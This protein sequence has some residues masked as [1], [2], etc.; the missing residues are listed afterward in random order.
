MKNKICRKCLN[1]NVKKD[2]FKRWKQRYKCCNCWYVFQNNRR[3]RQNTALW[4]EYGIWK[5]TYKQ[6][7][8]KHR[9][10]IPSIQ[11]KLDDVQ[12]NKQFIIP[13]ETVIIIDTTY[14]WRSFGIM[15][16]RS[17]ELRKNLFRKEVARET[18]KLYIDWIQYLK[19]QWWKILAIVSDGKRWL[20]WWFW[21][22]PTQMCIFHQQQI[23]R[24]YITKNPKLEANIEFKDISSMIWKIRKETITLWL[25]DRYRRYEK[26]LNERN[27]SKCYVHIRTR[28][29]YRSLKTNLEYLYV[30]I[31]YKW[32]IDI[33]NTTNSLESIFWH[34]KQKVWLHRWLRKDRKLKLIDEFLKK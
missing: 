21:E 3:K 30:F 34:M 23:I 28:K 11:R 26:F 5:Q 10:S 13:W 8:A 18:K 7:S 29:A 22:I 4:R 6:L 20:L 25:E 19:D 17:Y 12:V 9:L 2:W 1:N 16:F 33:P 31:D 15:T 27:S 32:K 24:R 14:F